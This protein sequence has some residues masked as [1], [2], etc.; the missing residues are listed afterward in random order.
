MRILTNLSLFFVCLA[1]AGC[2][3]M[4]FEEFGEVTKLRVLAIRVD[5]PEIGPGETAVIDALVVN[6]GGEEIAYLWEVCAF[7]DGPDAYYRCA[8]QDGQP[9]GAPLG[10]T[11]SV[12]LPYDTVEA[13]LGDIDEI[14]DELAEIDLGDFAGLPSCDRG[15][16]VTIRLTVMVGDG[17]GESVEV[18]TSGLLLLNEE[19][20]ALGTSNNRPLLDGVLLDNRTSAGAPIPIVLDEENSAELQALVEPDS[21]AERYE[22]TTDDGNTTEERERLQLTWFST[23][24]TIERT[25][26]YYSEES[27]TTAELQSNLLDLTTGVT[28][29]VVGDA[30]VLYLVLRDTRGGLDFLQQEFVIAPSE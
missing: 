13:V 15:F 27:V 26:T 14:C 18:A 16:P 10:N 22:N 3:D 7:T 20:A 5:P 17:Q 25:W 19:E 9:L 2:E 30:G 4:G 8:E 28:E 1:F 6:P 29:G 23:I 24:G 11:A 21:A 12:A